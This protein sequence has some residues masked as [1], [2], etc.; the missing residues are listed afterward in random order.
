MLLKFDQFSTF[1]ANEVY[2]IIALN[3]GEVGSNCIISICI[4]KNFLFSEL[5]LLSNLKI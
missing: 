5:F 4:W 1:N 2:L 3:T